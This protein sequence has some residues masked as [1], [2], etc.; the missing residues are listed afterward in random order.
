MVEGIVEGT[1][2]ED[3]TNSLPLDSMDVDVI[4]SSVLIL[5]SDTMGSWLSW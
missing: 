3:V 5:S 1:D 4:S 2:G